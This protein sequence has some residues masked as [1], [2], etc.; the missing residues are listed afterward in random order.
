M[1]LAVLFW[2]DECRDEPDIDEDARE[3]ARACGVGCVNV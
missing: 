1:E 3:G 2:R